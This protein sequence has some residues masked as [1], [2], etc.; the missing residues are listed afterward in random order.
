MFSADVNVPAGRGLLRLLPVIAA[1]IF[2][3]AMCI[4]HA[5]AQTTFGSITGVV[6]DPS[7]AAGPHGQITVLNQDTGLPRHQ[8]TAATGVYT[9]PDLPPGTYRVRFESKGFDTAERQGVLLDANHVV[10]IDILLAV[11]AASTK[12]EVQGTVP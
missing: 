6:T 7:H 10:T 4:P 3:G 2:G 5:F 12:V 11:G 1:T 8:T 9:V